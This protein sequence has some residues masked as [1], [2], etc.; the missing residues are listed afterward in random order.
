LRK[1]IISFDYNYTT[2]LDTIVNKVVVKIPDDVPQLRDYFFPTWED[3][4]LFEIRFLIDMNIRHSI[5]IPKRL[6][7]RYDEIEP[8][9]DLE[10]PSQQR[11]LAFDSE[12]DNTDFRGSVKRMVSE[13]TVP[14]IS[15]VFYDSYDKRFEVFLFYPGKKDLKRLTWTPRIPDEN[16]RKIVFGDREKI[17]V[18]LRVFPTEKS[19]SEAIVRYIH[20]RGPNVIVAWNLDG[21][22]MPIRMNRFKNIGVDVKPLSPIFN[23]ARKTQT[24]KWKK[25]SKSSKAIQVVWDIKN[26]NAFDLLYYYKAYTIPIEGRKRSYKLDDIGQE[27]LDIRKIQLEKSIGETWRENPLDIVKYNVGDV[28][29]LVGIMLLRNLVDF[30]DSLRRICGIPIKMSK[31]GTKLV[32]AYLLRMAN[33]KHVLP[34]EYTTFLGGRRKH[35]DP[36]KKKKKD[37]DVVA[38]AK[39][40]SSYNKNKGAIKNVGVI[41]VKALYPNAMISLN[42]CLSTKDPEGEILASNGIR[43]KK[44]PDGY[45]KT[46]LESFGIKRD[47][48]K[49]EREKHNE[50]EVLYNLY[51]QYQKAFKSTTNTVYGALLNPGF[52]LLDKDIG[53][54]IPATGKTVLKFIALVV[55]GG[56]E[57]RK[58]LREGMTVESL[59]RWFNWYEKNRYMADGLPVIY[60]DSVLGIE[61][62]IIKRDGIISVVPIASLC[63]WGED[64][65]ERVIPKEETFVWSKDEWVNV[66]YVKRHRVNKNLYSVTTNLGNCTATEDHSFFTYEGKEISPKDIDENTWLLHGDF[67]E[68]PTDNIIDEE[69]AWAFGYILS[70]AKVYKRKKREIIT[71]PF[72]KDRNRKNIIE[73]KRILQKE[74]LI[75]GL[76]IGEETSL[77]GGFFYTLDT[78]KE[79]RRQLNRK[80]QKYFYKTNKVTVPSEIFSATKKAKESF[81]R[82]YGYGS[83]SRGPYIHLRSVQLPFLQGMCLI[84]NSLGYQYSINHDKQKNFLHLFLFTKKRR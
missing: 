65:E 6:N 22:D 51:D 39:V 15:D 47:L 52:R 84:A 21:F 25:T 57:A 71:G 4:V 31:Y 3:N 23:I 50:G 78:N 58:V 35:E 56:T 60:G 10:L 32:D 36:N 53:A 63:E 82:G 24:D 19:M 72:A 61:P 29:I 54:A 80:L 75:E 55:N 44:S 34:S 42:M 30:Y 68:L 45:I 43:F 14:L 20:E 11:V 2:I 66:D 76:K 40:L 49:V 8:I 9:D 1:R 69:L 7:M 48:M 26:V 83:G 27:E 64:E 41:D 18:I 37:E 67:P 77:V 38:G 17:D 46:M 70:H 28:E 74:F 16:I 81:F 79:Q 62:V 12:Y 13:A 33:G 73:L 59:D 5:R